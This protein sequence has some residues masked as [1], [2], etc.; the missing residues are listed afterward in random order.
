M[1]FLMKPE[2]TCKC[3]IRSPFRW[4]DDYR[5]SIFVKDPVFKALSTGTTLSQIASKAVDKKREVDINY[6]YVNR[7]SKKGTETTRHETFVQ[8]HTRRKQNAA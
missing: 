8:H 3:C 4:Q 6:G 7:I 2:A 5:P 1:L